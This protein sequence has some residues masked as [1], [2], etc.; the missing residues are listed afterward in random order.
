MRGELGL[1]CLLLF[2][3]DAGWLVDEAPPVGA[4][5]GQLRVAE[6]A[7]AEAEQEDRI[8]EEVTTRQ[9]LG[10]GVLPAAALL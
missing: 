6:D 1:L 9:D 3:G 7:R 8:G 10:A 5:L 2:G 4:L